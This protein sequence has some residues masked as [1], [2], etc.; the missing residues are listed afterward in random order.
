MCFKHA[1]RKKNHVADHLVKQGVL[2]EDD[3][4]VDLV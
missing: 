2:R 1:H 3:L 4:D